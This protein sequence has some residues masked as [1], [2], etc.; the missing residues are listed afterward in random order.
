MSDHKPL[1]F[2]V[3]VYFLAEIESY[4]H[5]IEKRVFLE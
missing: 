3:G 2:D 5:E 4:N 1:Y